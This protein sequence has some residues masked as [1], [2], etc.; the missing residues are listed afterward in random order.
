M[1][2]L[3]YAQRRMW[4]VHRFEGPSATYNVPFR[5]RL[6]GE[7]DVGALGLAVRD[8]VGRHES[9]RTV[10]VEDEGGVPFQRVVPLEEVEVRVPVVEAG[11]D[12]LEGAVGEAVRYAFDLAGEIPLRAS[13]FRCGPCEH[14]LV[15]L[16][17]H[18]AVDGESMAPLVR[19]LSEA[20]RARVAGRAPRWSELPVQYGD[21]TLWQRELLG[22]EGDP[23]S[24]AAQQL[25][26]WRQALAGVPQPLPLP[27]DR[28]RPPVAGRNGDMVE[29]PIEPALRDALEELAR[30]HQATVSMVLQSALAVLLHRLGSGEDI[31][32]GCSIAGRTDEALADLVGFFV[33]TW[34]LR[35]DVSGNPSF[36]EVLGRVRGAA[37]AAYN[38]QDVPFERLVEVVNPERSTAYHPLFQVAFTWQ[39]QAR[40][41]LEL[42]GVSGSLEGV[43]TGTAKFDLEFSFAHDPDGPG[44]LC[45]LEFATDLF[46]RATVEAM[47]DRLLR[48]LRQVLAEPGLP[49]GTV[50]VLAPEER[51][52]L[53][54]EVNDTG[55]PVSEAPVAELFERRVAAWSG[56]VALVCGGESVS[57]G[58]LDGRA[59]RLA[60]VLVGRGV[61]PESV[62]G[63]AL[64]RSP[65]WVVAVLAVMKAGGVYLPV[66][67]A[68]P[69]DRI[70]F[71]VADSGACLM[72]A[73]A[74]TVGELPELS[75]PVL[76]TDDPHVA[77]EL[78]GADPAPLADTDRL[79]PLSVANIAYV[80]YTSG[81][82]GR[83]K[84][85]AVTHAGLASLLRTHLERL[86]VSPGS[87]VLQFASP[88]FDASV[89]ELCMGVLSGATLVLADRQALAPG[90]PLER[91][92]SDQRVTHVT[93][94]PPVLATLSD[95]ALS[96]VETLVVAGDASSPELVAAWCDGR[97]VINA[98]GPTETTVCATM[99][100]PLTGDGRTSP[101]G[102]PVTN[103]RVFVLDAGLRPVPPGVPGELY[104]AGPALARGYVHRAVLTAERFVACPFGEPGERMY[105]TGDVVA[106]TPDGQLVFQGRAD[107]QVKVRGYRIEPGEVETAL[108][109]H[110]R[111]AQAVV[112]AREVAGT[113]GSKQLVG[114]VVPAGADAAGFGDVEEL[115]DFDFDL[116]AGLSANELRRFLSGRLPEFMVPSVFVVLGRLPL[117]PNGKV[118][119]RALPDPEFTGAVY[120]AP[121]N[122]LEET[123]AA[124]FSEVLGVDRAGIDDDFFGAG[125]DSIRS[126][127]VVSRA[128]ARGVELSA[129]DVFERRTVARLAEAVNGRGRPEGHEPGTRPRPSDAPLVPVGSRELEAWRGRYP[130]LADVWPLAPLQE[131]LLFHAMLADAAFDAY[132]AQF[133]VHLSG[134]VDPDRLCAAGQALLDRHANL[135]SAF[136][137]TDSGDP[138]QL[139]V[140]GVRLPWHHIDLG[141]LD[142]AERDEALEQFLAED[143]GVP[144]DPAAPPMLRLA[145]VTRDHERSE[146][147]VTAHHVLFDGWSVPLLLQD[148]LRLYESGG[149]P[150]AL[151]A[152]PAFRDYL[153]WL[154]EQDQDASA[155]AWA[156]ELDGVDEPTLL[157]AG[158]QREDRKAGLGLVDVPL[159]VDTAREL[160]RRAAGLGVT[161]N[162]VVQAA[163]GVLLG[164]L[165][166]RQDVVFGATVS[167]RPPAVP[168]VDSMVGLF[169]NTVPV[170]VRCSPDTTL[171]ELMTGLQKRQAALLDHHHYGLAD[172]QRTTGLAALFDTVIGFESYPFDR[173]GIEEASTAA[174]L[175]TT[176]VATSGGTHYPLAVLALEDPQLR[177][178]VQYHQDTFDR[179]AVDVIAARFAR[180]LRQVVADPG[181]PVAM[182]DVLDA[183]ERDWLLTGLND[184]ATATVEADTVPG[185]FG[186]RVAAWSGSVALVCGGESVS[187]GELD[188]RANRLARVL[189]GRGVGPESVVGVA[190]PRSPDWVVAVL[191]VMKAGGVYLPVDP[192]YPVDRI[193]FMVADSGACLM[194]ADATTVGELPELSV[195]VLRTDDPHVAGEVVGADPA[196]LADTDRLGPLSVANIAY[197]IYTSGSTG[198]PKGVAVTHAGLASLLRTHLE[199]LG[200]SP[201]SRVLQFASP[202]FDASV[203]ELCMGVLSGATLVLAD[204]QALAP[205]APLERTISDQ[206]VTHVTL[207]PPVLATLSDGALSTVETLVVAG[208]ASSPELVAAWCDGRRVINAY[209]PTETTVCATMSLPLTGDGRTPPIGGPVTNARV[210]VLDAGLR[211]VPPGVPGELYVAGPALARGYVHRAVL[212]AERFVACPF[213]E[214]GERMYRTG[215][216][217]RWNADGQLEYVG[218]TDAQT[219]IRGFRVE[220]GEVETALTSHPGVAQAVVVTDEDPAGGQRLVA[221]AVLGADGAGLGGAADKIDAWRQVHDRVYA[222]PG[223]PW[224]EDFSGWDSRYTGEPIPLQEMAAWRDAAVERIL[225]WSPG[226]LLEIGVGTGLLM[227]KIVPTVEEYWATDLSSSVTDRLREQAAQAGYAERVRL[228]CQTADDVTGLPRGHFD[229]VVLNSVVQYFPDAVYLDRVLRQ[230]MELL[231]PGG[232]IVVGDVR[233]AGSLRLFRAGVHQARHPDASPSV[234]RAAVARAIR[235]EKELLIDPEWFTRWADRNGVGAVDVRLKPGRAHN[236]LTRHRYEVVLH[237]TPV[238]VVPLCDVPTWQWGEQL[239]DLAG[240]AEF[241]RAQGDTPVRIAR[242]PNARL[243]GEAEAAAAASLIDAPATAHRPVDPH[244]LCAW[245]A[246][247]G[248]D[249]LVTWSTNAVECFDVVVFPD[250]RR[251]GRVLTGGFLPSGRPGRT[252]T[253]DPAGTREAGSAATALR[254]H[255]AELLPEYLVPSAVMVVSEV[256]LTPSGKLDKRALPAPDYG[257]AA[258]G[259]EP[260]T[261][262]EEV[263]CGLFA[264]VLGLERVGVDDNFFALGGHSLL[265][266]KLI[267]RIRAEL[268][269]EIAVKSVFDSGTVAELAKLLSTGLRVRPKLRRAEVWPDRLPLSFAQRR[270]WFVHRFEGPSATY[271][272]PLRVRLRGELDESALELAVRDV[273]GRHESLRTVVVEDE[274]GVPFQ[275]VVPLEEVEVRVPVVE[276]GP[277]GL[278]GAVG[279]AVRYAFDLAGE[280]PLRASVFR[281]GPCE[282]V[283]VLLIHHIAVDGESMAPLVRDLSEAYRARVAGRA[284]R[285]SELPVQYGDYTLW[286]RELLG[287]EGD[288][289]SVAAQQLGYWRQAL[290]GVPQPLP[291]PTD[292]P[293]PSIASN[294]GDMVEFTMD[295]EML[296]VAEELARA[297]GMT[298]AMVF[299]SA[300]AVLLHQLTG[301]DDLTIGSPIANR[302]DDDL[303]D[304]IGFFANTWVLRAEVSGNPSFEQL[305]G[306]VREAALTAYNNQDAPFE[307]L[308]EVVNPERS[309]AYHPLF[310]VAFVWQN[311]GWED[312]AFEGLD[313]TL[314]P[315]ATGVARFDLE[316]TMFDFPGQ[317]IRGRID[318]ATDLFEQDTA[319]AMA[320]RLVRVVRQLVA[321]PGTPIGSVDVLDP[322]E[323]DWLLSEVNDTAA[324]VRVGTIPEL[325]ERQVAGRPDATAVAFEGE[326]LTYRELDS[327]A[328]RLARLLIENGVRPESVVAVC[329]PRSPE[330]WTAALAVTKAGGAYLPV[331]PAYPAERIEFMVKDSE[332]HLVIGNA[333]TAECLPELSAPVIRLDDPDVLEALA[334]ADPAAL[335]DTDRLGPLSVANTAYVIYTSGSTGL[336]KGV[337]VTHVGLASLLAA[338][339]ERLEVTPRSR[340]LQFNSPSFDSSVW[341]MCMALFSGAAF[342]L[343]VQDELAAGEP[344]VETI[345]ENRVTH[346]LLTPSVLAALPPGSLPTVTTLTVAGEPISPELAALWAKDR[347]MAN[348]YGPTETTVC[349][350]LCEALPGDGS[351][352]TVGRP[353]PNARLY[354]LDALLRPVPK[355]VAGELYVAGAGLARGYLGRAGLTA[356]RFVACPFGTPGERMYRTGDLV[357]WNADGELEFVGRADTQVKLRGY[358]IEPEE[359]EA[360]LLAHPRVAQAVVSVREGS[361]TSGNKQLVGYVVPVGVLETGSSEGLGTGDLDL[362]AG[363]SQGELRA[364]LSG[365]LPEFMVPSAIVVLDRL[366]MTPNGK[367]DRGA[368]PDPDHLG[369]SYRAPRTP[370][371]EA[372][373]AVFAEVLGLERVGIDDDFFASSGDSIQSIQVVSRARAHGVEISP[374]D[375][376]EHRTVARLAEVVGGRTGVGALLEEFDGGGVGSM[377]LLPVARWFRELGTGFDRVSQSMMVELPRGI[378]HAGLTATLNA[379]LDHH[380]MLRSRLLTAGDGNL[381]VVPR[382]WV[383]AAKL[384]RRV[385]CDGRWDERWRDRAA[386]ELHAAGGRLAPADGVMA[387]FVWF[388]A[389]GGGADRLLIVLHHLVVDGVSWRILLPDLAAAWERVRTGRTSEPPEL[390]RVGTSMRRWAHALTEEAARP[391]RV[392]ELPLWRSMTEGPD[393]LLGA[394]PLDPAVD[395]MSTVDSMWLRLPAPLTETLLTQLPRAFGGGV[396]DGLLAA[397]TLAVV[398]WRRRRGIAD[399]SS[400]L[401]RVEGHGREEQVV[402]GA[403]VSRTVGWFTSVFPVRLDIGGADPRQV[404]EDSRAAGDM[405]G[406]IR[407]Q[408]RALPDK[409][410]GYGL[411]RYANPETAAE[412]EPCSTGQIAFNYLGRFSAADMPEELRGRGWTQARDAAELFA[413]PDPGTPV[414][415]VLDVNAHIADGE[416]GPELS[417]RVAFPTGVLS[418]GEASE[419]VELWAAALEGLARCVAEQDLTDLGAPGARAVP[420]APG[421]LAAWRDRYPGLADVWPLAPLQAGLLVHASDDSDF[422]AYHMQLVLHLS[423]PVDPDRMRAAGQA[424]LDRYANLRTAFLTTGAGEPVQLAVDG[425]ALPWRQIDLGVL[426]E[427]ARDEALQ[428]HLARDRDTHFDPAAPPMLRMTLIRTGPDSSEL[429]FSVHHVLLDGWSGPLLLQELLQLYGSGGDPSAMAPAPE[430]RD[431]LMWL[432]EQDQDASARAWAAELDGVEPTLLAPRA[433]AS[434]ASK[435]EWAGLDVVDVPLSVDTARELARR[436]AGLGVTLNTVVQVAWG[437][438]LGQLTGRRDVVF[439]ATVSGRPPQVPGVDSMIGLF[440][441]N[442]PVRVRCST[443]ATL[444]EL[445]TGLHERQGALLDHHQHR[446]TD[447][448]QAMGVSSLFDTLLVFESYPIDRAGIRDANT[449]AGVAL[450]GVGIT[451]GSHYPLGVAAFED[452]HLRAG[453]QYQRHVYDRE[454][455]EGIA[456]RF[457][458]IL[459]R[460]ASD[461]WNTAAAPAGATQEAEAGGLGPDQPGGR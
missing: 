298:V 5:V 408:L 382:G 262:Q 432:S 124:V 358:R 238:D 185:L 328:N 229:T 26:Y 47:G 437:V 414:T 193:G 23:A 128:R 216:L 398:G 235:A 320:R 425:V 102:G 317:G 326:E 86:G 201:G 430:Y 236:E 424:L 28:P 222:T 58:E 66:D 148:L 72:V 335:M 21:Y 4:F 393:P 240:I 3:S 333:E 457:A 434:A 224:G 361:R 282:H 360:A 249:A 136:V 363:V 80:I 139:V 134:R 353:I 322:A 278:E 241:R 412:L 25:G 138:V 91:T 83:P 96:T 152:P 146:L 377:P 49:V 373:A 442:V 445:T 218:R 419:L 295:P 356:A 355:G 209:G 168:D 297:H 399:D 213:G 180:V 133:V 12:G 250:G 109:S 153:A 137:N 211:P 150:A 269:V 349:P 284:P 70:G 296:A 374:R 242:I 401:L 448:E 405:I 256:P 447:I 403:D 143:R 277:D 88:S 321:E 212:T 19:D 173:G 114:Y 438:L 95:G 52:R 266:T 14:V 369:E 306:R 164:R 291:L 365:R 318:Y 337:A 130:G 346:V 105:R 113:G 79:G 15:L 220:P 64:P 254:D 192:A 260:R 99:S 402:P 314:E 20:Y 267:R 299:Q 227:A 206:R 418:M 341:E 440:I 315:V 316:V 69:V 103:A 243:T 415:A 362:S 454:T 29:F 217:V 205:G 300:L 169:I 441:N 163:W 344:L 342:V 232:R 409:G 18:I 147:V 161:L 210:F 416:Q 155:G 68:Y 177:L 82:T 171:A 170:R 46:D 166:G 159:S 42:P 129:R 207:P 97:R 307:R 351:M 187:Y 55:V 44:M 407:E 98:Y 198:R 388:A 368:L 423:G 190:L 62:V 257:A 339:V 160:A 144:F 71:M 182:T 390:P 51:D 385:E 395:V 436:A 7:L 276:A 338:H 141:G 452:P 422:D 92:I 202:S 183:E 120:R 77:G 386:A 319:Q 100:L 9:L 392:A 172:I 48:V 53:L 426:E 325:F 301:R 78:A 387:Q 378:D 34:V 127:Q 200:V 258:D 204:R 444:A 340:V 194:V 132:H 223:A 245:A 81:S 288:P 31:T 131:G 268:N 449:T 372:L 343:A 125:G 371:E 16:I 246:Q 231:A 22:D 359:I 331:D 84:G 8:V 195:P 460:F 364:F 428:R 261:P 375:V 400:V 429:V 397:L 244:D 309:T 327:R 87:R 54:S 350:S 111:V 354:V 308:V 162:T 285:W 293:R 384:I 119:R 11:P 94:P 37:L 311:I 431:Y 50:D 357:R 63:V 74:A 32:L 247:Q 219:K 27:T 239:G 196:P 283:L 461:P 450:T 61:G 43:R 404:L 411:L 149:A 76:R 221:Y 433:A 275:R 175:A 251:D 272:S 118:D 174:G 263:L 179:D 305:L 73:D 115:R 290:A 379:V 380:D 336:P 157:A 303:A 41:D 292:R 237:K 435:G 165:T 230:A 427:P 264:E 413:E 394:R 135:R 2:P 75:V 253:N 176:G 121:R 274:G 154:S 38:N 226:R 30:T 252:L 122:P 126:I 186:R 199:R 89:W 215:D 104:V 140:D 1:I 334:D 279:E 459:R 248:W 45:Q 345:N 10:V 304:L 458:R 391:E 376:F 323:R 443:D 420:V 348:A 456:D 255:V 406:R 280:I 108:A 366:P 142:E 421:E 313:A 410:I 259:K 40:V 17:H 265:A 13:V 189:V 145:L 116:S 197:V 36:E 117:T 167:G 370:V 178:A 158:K 273:V 289:A 381:E 203:W 67:P 191:A 85:V 39:S 225:S 417:A 310:Q 57:Y 233:N 181:V 302:T 367:V 101:I 33:N 156:A 56:S 24:V 455:V 347:R 208:D 446:L 60:R 234:V 352:P 383:D 106:W 228:R 59:N 110:P 396:D 453:L 188:G 93:L 330:L 324:P 184:T 329:L 332:A 151:P 65:D 90:A 35:A 123:L 107:A 6:R 112:V 214:P 389:E 439:G 286:Q 294:N 270:M 271:N 281:C 451:S 312:F 287:D